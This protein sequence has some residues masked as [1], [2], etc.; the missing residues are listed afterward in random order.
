MFTTIVNP[1]TKSIDI[2]SFKGFHEVIRWNGKEVTSGYVGSY[3][4]E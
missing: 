2:Y 4:Y 1:D 3:K